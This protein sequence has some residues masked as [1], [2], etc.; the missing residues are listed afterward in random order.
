MLLI[1]AKAIIFG[2]AA[3]VEDTADSPS[4]IQ[5]VTSGSPPGPG[6][7]AAWLPLW[8]V[9]VAVGT[10][11]LVVQLPGP[12]A[13][14]WHFFDDA[15]QLLLLGD[16]PAG[17][18]GGL[19][20]YR[21][22]PDFQFGPL[23]IVVAA[24][25]SFLGPT[26]GS[27]L[28]MLAASAAG[29]LALALLLDAVEALVPGFRREVPPPVLLLGGATVV[30]AWGDVAVR[31]A[32]I[33]DAIALLS[34][35]AAVRWCA[36][37]RSWPATLA[38]AVAAAAK[39][40]A[41]MFAPLALLPLPVNRAGIGRVGLVGGLAALTWAPFVL[42]EPQTLDTSEFGIL[43]DPTSVLRAL[44]IADA[45]TPAWTRPAQLAGGMIVVTGLVVARRWPAAVLAGMAWRLLLEP[46]ANRY[47]TIGLVLGA[48]LVELVHRRSR[49]PWMTVTAAA[50]LEMTAFPGA[51]AVPGRTLR[52]ACVVSALA[53]SVAASA[54]PSSPG[55]SS[56]PPSTVRPPP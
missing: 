56:S 21:D 53:A 4:D 17:Q 18:A 38:L 10:V 26:A 3:H 19:H 16:G 50:V 11:T 55:L 47:Y 48:L 41:I 2:D 51:P 12:H 5:H 28:A 25:L 20:L 32:H 39:P 7:L 27:W 45:T 13:T 15:A 44:G 29:L 40:W 24:P 34:I 43:N 14:A 9:F 30:I 33:D 31:T 23:S 8:P 6:R 37:G 54:M 22:R 49:L 36:L 35:V 1:A 52:M 46:G 42:A